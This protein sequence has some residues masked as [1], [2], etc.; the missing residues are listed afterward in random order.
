MTL[1]IFII[2]IIILNLLL[3]LLLLFL[4][5]ESRSRCRGPATPRRTSPDP[6]RKGRRPSVCV[7]RSTAV[8][9]HAQTRCGTTSTP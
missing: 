1:V 7:A 2:I 4:T 6:R 8:C 9:A 3:L 5:A